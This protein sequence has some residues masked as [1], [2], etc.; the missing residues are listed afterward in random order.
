MVPTRGNEGHRLGAARKVVEKDVNEPRTDGVAAVGAGR[1][2]PGVQVLSR[3]RVRA[4][5]AE[6]MAPRLAEGS[7]GQ[8]AAGCMGCFTNDHAALGL[9]RTAGQRAVLPSAIAQQ[10]QQ[11]RLPCIQGW[12]GRGSSRWPRPTAH[13]SSAGAAPDAW[14]ACRSDAGPEGVR[15]MRDPRSMRS[16]RPVQPM[17]HAR[18]RKA[19]CS[20]EEVPSCKLICRA[21][22]CSFPQDACPLWRPG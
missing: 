14:P 8:P 11:T 4:G 9:H 2:V 16:H 3:R 10:A 13:D 21:R 17:A 12:R 1:R 7:A 5:A 15:D 18:Q 6:G 22:P 20:A 19:R